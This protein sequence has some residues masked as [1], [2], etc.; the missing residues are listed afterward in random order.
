MLTFSDAP[1]AFT[2]I[3]RRMESSSLAPEYF[4]FL[5]AG[6]TFTTT[7]NTAEVHDL[8]TSGTY[9]F[10]AEGAM[11]FA[12]GESTELSGEAVSFKSNT[13]KMP[14]DGAAAALVARAIST[15]LDKRTVLQ[16]G[17]S[18]AQSTATK[19]SLTNC[20]ALAKAAA[21]AAT[22]GNAA[23]FSE[24]FKTTATATRKTVADRLTA[25]AR[26]CGS[27]T[28]GATDFYCTDVYGKS[29]SH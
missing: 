5:K 24:Y 7:I 3:Y 15:T 19:N 14:V 18:A 4:K 10:S 13:L 23:K 9:S 6:E 22:S 12:V 29:T 8:Q 2:G 28:S 17:C 26:E 20:A 16:S 27:T 21:S 1:G 11:R 25:V